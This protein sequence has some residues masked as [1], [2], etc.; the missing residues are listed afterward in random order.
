PAGKNPAG[1][2]PADGGAGGGMSRAGGVGDEVRLLVAHESDTILNTV[3]RL[4][5][6]AG[7]RVFSAADGEAALA[8]ALAEQPDVMVIDVALPKILGYEVVERLR[9]HGGAP[10]TILVASVYNRT[11][12]KRRPTTLY[13]ADDYI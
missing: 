1:R 9:S 6:D 7:Y 4:A 8:T 12:Y 3:R 13:G 10:R 2:N 5:E 11:G